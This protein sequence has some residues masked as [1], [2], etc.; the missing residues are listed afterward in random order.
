MWNP[1]WFSAQPIS[2]RV[3]VVIHEAGHL[4][5]QHLERMLHIYTSL[6]DRVQ[7]EYLAPIANIAADMATNDLIVRPFIQATPKLFKE[8]KE[9]MIFPEHKPYEFKKG[10]GFETY[11]ALLLEK[12]KKESEGESKSE[13]EGGGGSESEGGGRGGN[14][15]EDGESGESSSVPDWVKQSENAVPPKPVPWWDMLEDMT[16]A[17]VIRVAGRARRETKEIVRTAAEQ[18]LKGRGTIPAHLQNLIDE[19][20]KPSTLPWHHLLKGLL[21]SAVASKLQESVSWP[22][23]ALLTPT[24]VE[25]GLE[26]Y[27]GYQKDFEFHIAVAIDTSGSVS[28]DDFITFLSEIQGIKQANDAI[29][30]QMIM[31]DA[32]IQIEFLLESDQE[33]ENFTTRYGY[34]GTDFT[35]PLKRIL[36][37]D[38]ESDWMSDA[39]R[40]TQTRPHADL[41]VM[42]TD[43]YA[44]VSSEDSGPIPTY[45]PQCPLLWVITSDGTIDKAMGDRVVKIGDV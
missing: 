4:V 22:N 35:P 41:V 7:F 23:A 42:L 19:I 26:P 1:E 31:F 33:V 34:G 37:V 13:S 40:I 25:E 12:A 30:I 45:H 24:A 5:L 36:N 8:H 16:D 38:E 43:G 2:L 14:E 27:P 3:L 32:A 17:E 29:T 18:T 11:L 9:I 15:S 10:L 20:L 39:K 28:D 21:R 6:P 44:P